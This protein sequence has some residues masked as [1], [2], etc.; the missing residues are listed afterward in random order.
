VVCGEA[1]VVAGAAA[2][3]GDPGQGALDHPAARQHFEGVQVIGPSDDL[4]GQVQPAAGPRDELAGVAAVGPGQADAAAGAPQVPQQRPGGVAVLRAGGGGQDVQQQAA[5][6]DR[7]V[8][9]AAVDLSW[10][11]P[12]PG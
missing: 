10:R 3:A 8:P 7:D 9:L 2:V 5:G 12:S 6:V 4:H 1:F 11:C